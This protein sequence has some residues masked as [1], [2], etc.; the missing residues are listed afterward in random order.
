[1][2]Q[3]ATIEVGAHDPAAL[4]ARVRRYAARH[5]DPLARRVHAAAEAIYGDKAVAERLLGELLA[6]S[7]ND[8]ELLY[9]RGMRHRTAAED[10]DAEAR[11]AQFRLARNWF[12]RAHRADANH[13]QTLYRYAQSFTDEPEIRLG[14][15]PQHPAARATAR[16]AGGRDQDERRAML[17]LRRDFELAEALLRPLA[18]TAHQGP[19]AAAARAMLE[20][21]RAQDAEGVAVRFEPEEEEETSSGGC[22]RSAAPRRV[23][24]NA[25]PRGTEQAHFTP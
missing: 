13:F 19:L 5:N 21:A 18:G 20:K 15:Q 16:V 2:L 7:P 17:L 8:A 10:L 23:W 12:S 22:R 24:T 6:E 1:M 9:Y 11:T 4:L 25:C 14:E 3:Q